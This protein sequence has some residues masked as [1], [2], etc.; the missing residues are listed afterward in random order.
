MDNS[1]QIMETEIINHLSSFTGTEQYHKLGLFY[2]LVGTDGIAE[3]CKLCKCYWL[4]D[5]VGSVQHMPLVQEH[6][7]FLIWKVTLDENGSGCV[8]SA[9]WD[10]ETDGTY[11]SEKQVYQQVIPYTDFP[12]SDYEFYQCGGVLLLKSEY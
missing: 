12:L 11:S 10:C 7:K 8:V 9:Y 4:I 1:K 2:K 5:I 6:S 3:F